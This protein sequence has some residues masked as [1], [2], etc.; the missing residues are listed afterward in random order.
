MARYVF[1]IMRYFNIYPP[2]EEIFVFYSGLYRQ[3]WQTVR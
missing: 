2:P 1:D 3:T